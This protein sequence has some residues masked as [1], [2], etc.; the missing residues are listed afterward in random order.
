[1]NSLVAIHILVSIV[2]IIC[3]AVFNDQLSALS[4][5]AG[6]G[7][8]LLNLLGLSIAWPRILAKKQVALAISVIVFKFAI[9]VWILYVVANGKYLNL[10]WFSAGLGLVIISVIGAGI[11]SDSESSAEKG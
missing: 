6:T 5:A 7:A 4:V 1:M 9:L 3:V 2:A 8:S 10:G 11:R